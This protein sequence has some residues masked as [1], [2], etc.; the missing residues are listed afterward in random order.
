M[1]KHN[2]HNPPSTS[3]TPRF[4]CTKV[5]TTMKLNNFV[6]ISLMLVF[7]LL[8][9]GNPASRFPENR[10]EFMKELKL[11][12]LSTKKKEAISAYDYFEQQLSSGLYTDPEVSRIIAVSN[13]MVNRKLAATPYF[14][15]FLK[16][17]TAL[18]KNKNNH[19]LFDSWN[20]TLNDLLL[21][22]SE[23]AGTSFREMLSFSILYFEKG[24]LCN[25]GAS[26][27]WRAEANAKFFTLLEGEPCLR[28]EETDL[29]CFKRDKEMR[30]GGTS[31]AYFP[32]EKRWRGKGGMVTW[33]RVGQ[34]DVLCEFDVF[35]IPLGKGVY[36][37]EKAWLSYADYFGTEKV[38]GT[39]S[40]NLKGQQ[41]KKTGNYPVFES[42]SKQLVMPFGK[43]NITFK[44]GI[45]LKG[46]TL[47]GIGNE[48]SSAYLKGYGSNDSFSFEARGSRFVMDKNSR[49][50]GEEVA[51][52]IFF[53]RDSVYHP[54]IKFKFLFEKNRLTLQR[55]DR[56]SNRNP[57]FN[58]LTQTN[59]DSERLDWDLRT[60]E[61]IVNEKNTS[62]GNTNK[63][64]TFESAQYYSE[65]DY[66]R[67]QSV[68]SV[69]PLAVLKS[70]SDKEKSKSVSAEKYAQ[71]INTRFDV[72][73]IN[74]L[75]YDL[76]AKGYILYDKK[77]KQIQVLDKVF[78]Y[79]DASQERIDYDVLKLVS[80]SDK[81]NAKIMLEESVVV[82]NSV[83][84]VEFSPLQKVAAQPLKGKVK[85][86]K[87]RSLTFNGKLYAGLAT[88]RGTAFNFNY[89][90]FTMDLDSVTYYDL[91][92]Q[93]GEK[94]AQGNPEAF[95]IASRIEN[96]AGVLLIDA[97]FNKSGRE[98]IAT[99]PAFKTTAPAYVYYD[100]EE[101]LEGCYK[102]DSFH[103]KLHPFTLNN[104]DHFSAEN[105]HFKGQMVSA[106]IFPEFEETMVLNEEDHSLGFKHEV[107]AEGYATYGKGHFK[108][109]MDLSNEGLRAAG[110]ITYK[111]A[112]ID[113]EDLVFKPNQMTA[114][115]NSFS[116]T[117]DLQNGIPNV[118]GTGISIDWH[119]QKDSMYIKALDAPFQ[120]FDS[121][122][123]RLMDLLI[124]TPD[125]VKG[126]GVFEWKLGALESNLFNLGAKT[127]SADTANLAVKVKGFGEL[128]LHTNNVSSEMDFSGNIAFVQANSDTV[129]TDFPNNKYRTSM[130]AFNWDF[131]KEQITFLTGT[132]KLGSFVALS[133][134]VDSLNFEGANAGLDLITNELHIGGVPF[135]AVADAQVF[136]DNGDVKVLPGGKI[137]SLENAKIIADTKNK[138]H[139]FNKAKVDILARNKY[140]AS[141]F[142]EYPVGEKMQEIK[143]TDIGASDKR[144]VKKGKGGITFANTTVDH[145]YIDTPLSFKGEISLRADEANLSFDGFAQMDFAGYQSNWFKFEDLADRK[146]LQVTYDNDLVN[147]KGDKAFT[148]IFANRSDGKL[149][150]SFM[151]AL[152]TPSDNDVFVCTGLMDFN[153]ELQ[154]YAFG[155]SVRIVSGTKQGQLMSLDKE[156]NTTVEGRF[157][158]GPTHRYANTQVVGK[159]KIEKG[160]EIRN[161]EFMA[162]MNIHIPEKL[163]SIIYRAFN[164]NSFQLLSTSYKKDAFYEMV[165]ANWIPETRAMKTALAELISHDEL[166]IPQDYNDFTFTFSKLPMLWN[167]DY[168]SFLSAKSKISLNSINKAIFNKEVEAYVEFRK[169]REEE[170]GLTL[171][172]VAPNGLYYYFNY[173]NSI[174]STCSDDE[175]YM[176][177]L[178]DM[179][180]KELKKKVKGRD[181]DYEIQR[182]S[183]SRA[184]QFVNRVK[185]GRK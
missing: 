136:P 46:S 20:Q 65:H 15:D 108:G 2:E 73:T 107:P 10:V 50:A 53:G 134:E 85:M 12:L 112:T 21:S 8:A 39:F 110:T 151:S 83:D 44:G 56:G 32:A 48:Q 31:G 45:Q 166:R 103:F 9:I 54:S 120:L 74:S 101:T 146:N 124:L 68:A 155:D 137:P 66:R 113:S 105:F 127:I 4:F 153:P 1:N 23:T 34:A 42:A 115:A 6:S 118:L 158:V 63:K 99:F 179:S 81:T 57:F 7:P 77:T 82:A 165:L 145:L 18:K 138:Y 58:S 11:Y 130:N 163:M 89:E 78:H 98:D 104:L 51:A 161:F 28:F 69:H 5:T 170:D 111:W 131:G 139:V 16:S 175:Q 144:K 71:T 135:I 47:Y 62:I 80:E 184:K 177:L 90:P 162:G 149:Y 157:A 100:F 49:I 164:E 148:G 75:I 79:C 143:F 106:G 174:L 109:K 24:L 87:N 167:K 116:I 61:V 156:G 181:D 125:G 169:Y 86:G 114:T 182:V 93:T 26:I 133:E 72:S 70:L 37:I 159:A 41:Q 123:N 25:A 141:G 76:V 67:L 168:Q 117:E 64:V 55:G 29:V 154:Q 95:S 178:G 88:F 27:S 140:T 13:E 150:P 22:K 91:F 43:S 19:F 142:Y 40:D 176:S 172:L 185:E 183:I 171:Y 160:E 102:R 92:V 38:E 128:A 17:V 35:D 97:P 14:T 36:K 121:E 96:T 3:P 147:Y 52:A 126:R 60:N 152:K 119:P 132:D 122:E 129:T 33:A 84:V 180:D 30:I 59:I 173:R 94:D